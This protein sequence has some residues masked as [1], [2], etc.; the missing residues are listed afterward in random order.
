MSFDFGW[1]FLL[2]ILWPS[3]WFIWSSAILFFC[4]THCLISLK[5]LLFSTIWYHWA[6]FDVFWIFHPYCLR[7][8]GSAWYR[9][10]GF[11]V[12]HCFAFL[13]LLVPLLCMKVVILHAYAVCCWTC[14]LTLY[15]LSLI[16]NAY[17]Y[18]SVATWSSLRTCCSL[19]LCCHC[20]HTCWTCFWLRH[21]IQFH[22]C[23]NVHL[24]PEPDFAMWLV[25]LVFDLTCCSIWLRLWSF[26][27]QC[28]SWLYFGNCIHS[29]MVGFSEFWRS[30]VMGIH[31]YMI[32]GVVF[33]FTG[34]AICLMCL[35]QHPWS[36][37][38]FL[39]ST[40]ILSLW[41]TFTWVILMVMCT[42]CWRSKS[43]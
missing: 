40:I 12:W 16:E 4:E 10:N 22:I 6:A 36:G 21:C 27:F 14:C 7:F 15:I 17:M 25:Y 35:S 23:T 30:W 19:I 37:Y 5:F 42:L 29:V 43:G 11:T 8:G 34:R 2:G 9:D 31:V 3:N 13:W 26:L 39:V 28:L 24:D 18:L 1:K 41:V 20:L 33:L 32:Y 38:Y